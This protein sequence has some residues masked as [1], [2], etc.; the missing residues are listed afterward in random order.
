MDCV[1]V[2]KNFFEMSLKASIDIGTNTAL[3]L[4]AD[5]DNGKLSVVREEQRVPR[6]GKGVDREG[7]LSAESIER[8]LKVIR[9]YQNLL[10]HDYPEIKQVIVT[11]TSAVRDASN[12]VELAKAI[13]VEPGW[14]LRILSGEEEA[15]WTFAGALSML[16]QEHK[17]QKSV[18]LDI[19][20]GST[21]V[22]LGADHTVIDRYSFSMGSIRFTERYLTGDPPSQ[23]E[24]ERCREAV[25]REFDTHLFSVSP[26]VQ[27]VGVAGTVTSLAF[28]LLNLAEYKPEQISNYLLQKN[29]VQQFI[30]YF[31]SHTVRQALEKWPVVMEGRADVM[32]AGLLILEGFLSKYSLDSIRVST[33]GIRHGAVLIG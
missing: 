11:G 18:I 21:E 12:R 1:G 5:V 33:G 20:G 28:I 15:E 2:Y 26:D 9:E 24:I 13:Q 29:D 22:A 25:R 8:V 10:S 6:L 32:L 14:K 4:V 16:S 27:A 23:S 31:S 3:L 17:Y 19:G 30:D 7:M